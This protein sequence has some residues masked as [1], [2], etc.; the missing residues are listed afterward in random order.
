MPGKKDYVSIKKNQHEKHV[1]K[2]WFSIIEDVSYIACIYG[3]FCWIGMVSEVNM[4]EQD[5]MV[6]FL[7]PHGPQKNFK[8]PRNPDRCLDSAQSILCTISTPVTTTGCI[9]NISD[10]EYDTILKSYQVF[11]NTTM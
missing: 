10:K 7:H 11:F 6:K 2:N 9:Y 8:W 4:D 3:D 1:W 5:L